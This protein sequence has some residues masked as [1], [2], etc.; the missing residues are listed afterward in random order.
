MHAPR[1]ATAA[2]MASLDSAPHRNNAKAACMASL[3][4]YT[5]RTALVTIC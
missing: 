3:D 1:T 2:C 5:A 4:S